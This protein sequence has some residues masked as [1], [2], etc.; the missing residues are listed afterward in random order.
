MKVQAVKILRDPTEPQLLSAAQS[1]IDVVRDAPQEPGKVDVYE[2]ILVRTPVE[3][4]NDGR[5]VP[6]TPGP[7]R[8]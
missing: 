7:P 6:F 1:M 3:R 8:G 2:L 4:T 5:I